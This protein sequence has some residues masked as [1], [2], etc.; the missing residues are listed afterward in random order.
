MRRFR[1]GR[2]GNSHRSGRLTSIGFKAYGRGLTLTEIAELP[3]LGQPDQAACAPLAVL[4]DDS[5]TTEADTRRQMVGL[6][7]R[8]P[9]RDTCSER[10]T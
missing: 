8:C 3:D 6:C 2:G 5:W 9:L 7:S 1:R 4:F 10:M